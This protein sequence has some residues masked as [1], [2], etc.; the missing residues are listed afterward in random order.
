[1]RSITRRVTDGESSES[2]AATAWIPATS[3]SGDVRLS[4]KPEAPASSAPKTNSSSSNVVRMT[5]FVPGTAAS[6]SLV[7][8]I[9]SSRHADI[10]QDD[11]RPE[12]RVRSTAARPSAASP[13]TTSPSSLPST[14]RRPAR[15]R[16]SSSTRRT[17]TLTARPPAWELRAQHEAAVGCLRLERS[18]EERGALAHADDPVAAAGHPAAVGDDRVRDRDRERARGEGEP[19]VGA[20][21]PVARRVRER[22]L[23]DPVRGAVDARGERGACS[24][25]TATSTAARRRGGARRKRVERRQSRR[26]LDLAALLVLAQRAHEPVDLRD[27]VAGDLLDRLE[28]GA[29]RV[30]VALLEQPGGPGL[31]E[32]DVDR[33]PRGVVEVARDARPLLGRREPPLALGVALGSRGPGLELGD[34]LPPEPGAVAGHP[35][36]APEEDPEEELGPELPLEQVRPQ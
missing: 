6:T 33:V 30:R 4:R 28:G 22:L 8:A 10:H 3:S 16:S 23:E 1:M 20:A 2:P 36:P 17:R 12:R 24:P 19:H 9:P 21:A 34:P 5:T 18:A 14:A 32:D 27:R 31:H 26:R 11:V 25:R 35:G 13:T 15:M 7:A 29:G